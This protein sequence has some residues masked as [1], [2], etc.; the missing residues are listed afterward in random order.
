MSANTALDALEKAQAEKKAVSKKSE[1]VSTRAEHRAPQ[2]ATL[3]TAENRYY[4][5]MDKIPVGMTYEWKRMTVAGKDDEEH[6][7]NVEAN[8]WTYVPADRH[9]ELAGMRAKTG[10]QI[11]RGGLALMERPKELTT[12]S[13]N[14]DSQR[15]SEQVNVQF[16]RLSGG[17]KQAGAGS[18]TRIQRS[19]AEIPA[20]D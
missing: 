6:Q 10:A 9:P 14:M 5:D 13:R 16:A 8:G 20:D 19:V 15:A 2:R 17:A 18:K 12:E 7:I 3:R 11:L 1:P 4:V